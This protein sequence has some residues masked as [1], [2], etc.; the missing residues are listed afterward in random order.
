MRIQFWVA[1]ENERE[2]LAE[3][4]DRLV[5]E[6]VELKRGDSIW[7]WQMLSSWSYDALKPTP[8]WLFTFVFEADALRAL[9]HL[10]D[11]RIESVRFL[12]KRAL[13]SNTQH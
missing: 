2:A 12:E 13:Q 10:G 7:R 3:L 5:G 4:G 9:E 6:T 11:D 8:P 1:D